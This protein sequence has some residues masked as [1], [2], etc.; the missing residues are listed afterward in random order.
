MAVNCKNKTMQ[1]T[2]NKMRYVSESLCSA[3]PS[4]ES[5]GYFYQDP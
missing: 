5:G 1:Q 3:D 2:L 4:E